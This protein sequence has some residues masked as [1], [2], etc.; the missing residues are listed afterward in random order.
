MKQQLHVML[1]KWNQKI[2]RVFIK[3]LSSNTLN[4]CSSNIKHLR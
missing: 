4:S 3:I 1:A 2:L